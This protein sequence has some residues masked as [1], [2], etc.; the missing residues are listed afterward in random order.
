MSCMF[1]KCSSGGRTTPK[2]PAGREPMTPSCNE[3][4]YSTTRNTTVR[5]KQVDLTAREFDLLFHFARNPDRVFRR[6][7]LLDS[8]WGYG[9]DGYEHTV[10]THINRL[11]AKLE[12]DPSEPRFVLTVWGVGYKFFDPQTGP[13]H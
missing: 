8:V 1:A 13:E 10:N 3:F 6:A 2:I 11:R 12:N 5:G 9:H 4:A 7:E